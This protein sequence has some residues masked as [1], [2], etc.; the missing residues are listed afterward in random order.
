[1]GKIL[2]YKLVSLVILC[3]FYP[4]VMPAQNQDIEKKES[5]GWGF[6]WKWGYSQFF[7]FN[8]FSHYLKWGAGVH[9]GMDILCERFEFGFSINANFAKSKRDFIIN[10][11]NIKEKDKVEVDMLGFSLSYAV[12]YNDYLKISPLAGTVWGALF[13]DEI[14]RAKRIEYKF[15]GTI[16]FQVEYY[17]LG[18]FSLGGL[19]GGLCIP[20]YFKYNYCLPR[21]YTNEINSGMHFVTI[22][23]SILYFKSNDRKR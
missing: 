10:N 9:M 16:G 14:S 8:D 1:M 11:N 15:T 19:T 12:L 22:G 18:N 3:C 4:N 17:P 2:K 23:L 20:F 7:P 21:R 13:N 6:S 5:Y